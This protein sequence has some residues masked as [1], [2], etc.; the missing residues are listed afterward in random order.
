VDEPSAYA[1]RVL[2]VVAQIPPGT[3]MSY[4]DVAEFMGEGSARGVGRVMFRWGADV[5]WHRVVMAD[6][7]PKPHGSDE[8]LA[9]L[10]SDDTPMTANGSRVDM[11]LA[12]WDGR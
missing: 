1:G 2:S 3:V 5:P 9:L 7:R 8:Q 12:R 10:R 11:R 6:G 4:G